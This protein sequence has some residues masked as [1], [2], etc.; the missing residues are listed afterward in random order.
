MKTVEEILAVS[1]N[2]QGEGLED[3][4][5]CTYFIDELR[6][7]IAQALTIPYGGQIVEIGV[8]YGRSASVYLQLQKELNLSIHLVEDWSWHGWRARPAFYEMIHKIGDPEFSI[9]EVSSNDAAKDWDTPIDFL[10]ID[11][12]HLMY[13]VEADCQNWLPWVKSGGIAVFHD[14]DQ[15]DV[16]TCIERYVSSQGWSLISSVARMQIWRKP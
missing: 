5:W 6:C 1:R 8:F 2:V 9:H 7:L 11:G 4:Q 16:S 10:H 12:L 14:S 13:A 3:H 15:T